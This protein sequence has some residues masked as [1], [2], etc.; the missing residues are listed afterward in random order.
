MHQVKSLFVFGSVLTTDFNSESDIDFVVDI[1][2]NNP[3]DYSDHYFTLKSQLERLLEKPV[4]LLEAKAIKNPFL[5]TSWI[6]LLK[7]LSGKRAPTNLTGA[8]H[9][10]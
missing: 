8:H 9:R 7:P 4:D 3:F 1:D 5:K 10:I 6:P 2:S